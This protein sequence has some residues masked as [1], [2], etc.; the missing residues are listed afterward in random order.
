V[1]RASAGSE[2]E[3]RIGEGRLGKGLPRLGVLR[4]YFEN[5]AGAEMRWAIGAFTAWFRGCGANVVDVS[6]PVDFEDLLGLHRT[7]IAAE[8][9]AIHRDRMALMPDAYPPRIAELVRDGE[10]V[11]EAEFKLALGLKPLRV[12]AFQPVFETCEVLVCPP[13]TGP[14]PDPST[15]GDPAL[16][17]PW[18]YLGFPTVTFPL[19]YAADGMPLGVQLIGKPGSELRLLLVAEWCEEATRSAH[20]R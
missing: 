11:P 1:I 18:S 9:A 10:A 19:G 4:G 20:S 5:R 12:Q 14:A 8:A 6:D 2:D 13:A 3:E 7:I 16:N 17:S 15:T